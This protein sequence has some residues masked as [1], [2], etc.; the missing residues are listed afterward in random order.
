MV[1]RVLVF[2]MGLAGEA[3]ARQLVKRGY[4]VI[5]A[6]DS[7]G[8]DAQARAAAIGID[9]IAA[10]TVGQIRDLVAGVDVVCPGPGVPV[11]HPVIEAA[12]VGGTP[13]WSE[14]ELVE[15]W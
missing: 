13:A 9:L 12:R 2:G 4:D 8:D 7:A 15:R 14:F 3:V 10:P 1:Q 6:D 5:A 11:H